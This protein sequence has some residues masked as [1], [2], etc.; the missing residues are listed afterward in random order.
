LPSERE[1]RPT[2]HLDQRPAPPQFIGKCLLAFT[3]T[4]SEQFLQISYAAAILT[5]I[6]RSPNGRAKI[7]IAAMAHS[8]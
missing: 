6:N 1:L 2:K 5:L 4:G 7:T 3:K 8:L